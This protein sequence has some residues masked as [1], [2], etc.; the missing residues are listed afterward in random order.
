MDFEFNNDETRLLADIRSIMETL[1]AE[2]ALEQKDIQPAKDAIRTALLHLAPCGIL[3]HM[4]EDDRAGGPKPSVLMAAREIV[5]AVSPSLMLSVGMSTEVFGRIL[6]AWGRGDQQNGL[7]SSLTKGSL[8]GAVALCEDT[9]NAESDPLT[10]TGVPDGNDVVLSGRKDYVV[11]G[12]IADWTAVIGRF[13]DENAIFLVEKDTAGLSL[14]DR[15]QTIG[16]DGAVICSLQLDGCRINANQLLQLQQPD[17]ALE[18]IRFWENRLLTG[19]SLGL[20]KAAV[21]DTAHYAKSHKSGGKPIIAYQTIGFKLAEMLT[22]FQTAQLMAYR[23]VQQPAR[24]LKEATASTLC[25]K[26]FCTEA[27]EKVAADALQILSAAGYFS[28]N[29][30]EHAYRCAKYGQIAGTSSEM[31]RIKIADDTLGYRS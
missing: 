14:N 23:A 19:L 4:V 18:N 10:T 30:T 7:L 26:V 11:N 16:Y 1:S 25:A 13:E 12:P 8:L 24:R 22:L 3:K 20:M 17:T 5:A 6:A 28:G 15:K 27:A 9:F 29:P 31:A 21:D 2:T